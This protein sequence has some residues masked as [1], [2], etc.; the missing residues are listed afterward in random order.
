VIFTRFL[1]TL[2]SLATQIGITLNPPNPALEKHMFHRT[3]VSRPKRKRT[4][5]N[6]NTQRKQEEKT[7]ANT[8]SEPHTKKSENREQR[9]AEQRRRNGTMLPNK[10]Y[11]KETITECDDAKNTERKETSKAIKKQLC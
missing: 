4:K 1:S 10:A 2:S 6:K 7:N 5:P 3:A 11:L 9:G 8:E